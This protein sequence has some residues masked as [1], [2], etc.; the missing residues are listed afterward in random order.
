M[1]SNR[2]LLDGNVPLA[3]DVVDFRCMSSGLVLF[4][5]V[6]RILLVKYWF[7]IR[8]R[9]NMSQAASLMLRHGPCD[10]FMNCVLPLALI[11]DAAT[12]VSS[13]RDILVWLP[14]CCSPL[15]WGQILDNIRLEGPKKCW[16]SCCAHDEFVMARPRNY[17]PSVSR[18]INASRALDREND[19]FSV[20]QTFIKYAS[21]AGERVS[22]RIRKG[23]QR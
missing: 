9:R 8:I 19:I 12:L 18:C 15:H 11:S 16:R 7:F 17:H 3:N 2:T 14:N 6:D 10:C 1:P 20:F 22:Q 13:R 23:S 21:S 4:S 5:A